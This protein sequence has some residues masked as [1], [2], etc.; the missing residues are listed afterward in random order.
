[1]AEPP[2]RVLIVDDSAF[3]RKVLRELIVKAGDIEIVDI[4]RDGLDALERCA[5]LRPDVV[6]L[7]LMM[8]E[9][10]GIGVLTAFAADPNPPAVVVVSSTA[11]DSQIAVQALQ[12]GAV[13]LVQKPTALATE[14]LYEVGEELIRQV[15]IAAASRRRSEP[16]PI[17]EPLPATGAPELIVVGTSTG[18]PRALTVVLSQ[19]PPDLKAPVAAVVHIP[20]GYTASLAERID[21]ESKLRVVEAHDGLEVG[22][23]TAVIAR[24]GMHLSVERIAP[25]VARCRVGVEPVGLLHR[26]SVD[27]L[28]SSAAAA[29]GKNVLGAVLTGMGDD[30]VLGARAIRERGGRVLTEHSSSCIVDG[31]PRAVVAAGLSDAQ[32]VLERMAAALSASR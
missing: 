17:A 28:F 23:G 14:R 10:D 3:A 26:P 11:V 21:R 22:P 6:T 13:A 15:R 1:M 24:G 27:V 25:S 4:A 32:V 2:I 29:F 16:P 12:L 5:A 20:P 18:G 7:D 9:L 8:P 30:G 19:L 31:M